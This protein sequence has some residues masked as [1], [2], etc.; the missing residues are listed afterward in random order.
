MAGPVA[1]YGPQDD[2]RLLLRSLLRLYKFEVAS[3]G[4]RP[5]ELRALAPRP[6]TTVVLDVDLDEP[7]WTEAVQALREAHPELRLLLITPSRS[8][9][10]DGQARSVGI[11]AVLRRPFA[12][13]QLAD[14]MGVPPPPPAPPE[15]A[16]AETGASG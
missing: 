11:S 3:E 2:V 1:I 16:V 5:N 10:V 6:G 15:P 4:A 9:R 12:L 14:L 13:R 7:E 8:A